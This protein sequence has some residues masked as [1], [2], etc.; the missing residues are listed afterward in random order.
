M[1]LVLVTTQFTE[2]MVSL[3]LAPTP[4]LLCACLGS[5][6]GEGSGYPVIRMQT[7]PRLGGLLTEPNAPGLSSTLP[8]SHPAVPLLCP[9]A[10]PGKSGLLFLEVFSRLSKMPKG[11]LPE[12]KWDA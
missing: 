9:L 7:T 12:M 1:K 3:G 4:K 5:R 11:R 2:M 8:S 10:L 6:A